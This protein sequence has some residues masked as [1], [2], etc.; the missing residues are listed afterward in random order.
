M[1]DILR[2]GLSFV[3]YRLVRAIGKCSPSVPLER[4]KNAS[5]KGKKR[6]RKNPG[7]Y[8]QAMKISFEPIFT[9]SF[10]PILLL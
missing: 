8:T 6:G 1:D 9:V 5:R 2:D 10:W 7:Y 3:K 4:Q